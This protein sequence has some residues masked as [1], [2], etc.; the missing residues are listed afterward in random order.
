MSSSPQAHSLVPMSTHVMMDAL[1]GM[2]SRQ[3]ILY[4]WLDPEDLEG[5]KLF[6][7][8]YVRPEQLYY[9][10]KWLQWP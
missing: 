5:M 9:V 6:S 10:V 8:F 2:D 7:A 1:L 3:P 4:S